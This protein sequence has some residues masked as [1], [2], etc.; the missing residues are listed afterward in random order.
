M[1]GMPP[2]PQNMP[3]RQQNSIRIQDITPPKIYD[4]ST[5]SKKLTSYQAFTIRKCPP[6]DPKKEVV[7]TWA[8]S[9]II[10]ERLAQE[11]IVK[12]I[13]KLDRGRSVADKKKSLAQ[14]QQG[15]ITTL[16]DSCVNGERDPAFEW[17]LV[18]LETVQKPVS[19]KSGKRRGLYET[20]TMT[21][22][23][24]RSVR[25]DLNPV[26][27]FQ[28][29]EKFKADQMRPPPPQQQ[30]GGQLPQGVIMIADDGKGKGKGKKDKGAK[31]SHGKSKSPHKRYHEHDDS[32]T[33]DSFSSDTNSESSYS[34]SDSIGTS[35]SSRSKGGHGHHRRAS[36]G[37]GAFR[38]HSKHS[39]RG[40]FF[41]EQ[42][43]HSPDRHHDAYGGAARPY[44][45]DVPRIPAVAALPAS[46][47][48]T[49][50]YF[51]G[52]NDA[53]AER[54]GSADRTVPRIVERVIEP[55]NI[56]SY[57][58]M[59]PRSER[60]SELRYVDDQY[61]D[62]LRREDAFRR[63]ELDA[64]EYIEGRLDGRRDSRRPSEYL[65]RRHSDAFYDHRRTSQPLVWSNREPFSPRSP[66]G[67]Y[68][69]SSSSGGW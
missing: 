36:H 52:K 59:E 64:E 28:Q 8:R 62:D 7:G 61:I 40:P 66:A 27:V 44:V 55:R 47:P 13:K 10:E 11:D 53:A 41:L 30:Q 6:R 69:P 45:P 17:S 56:I 37:R 19:L 65:D 4:E 31:G 21:V 32:S 12:Q 43:P 3:I 14:F 42:R 25:K 49:A 48:V 16:L 20:V 24:K 15:Q 35:I 23:V 33:G 38:S 39:P 60:H 57:G 63:R 1:P 54:Y 5:C 46:D 58:R 68:A 18:Q 9:E 51:A 67:R 2:M 50:A 29:I 34:G 22:Y 26:I